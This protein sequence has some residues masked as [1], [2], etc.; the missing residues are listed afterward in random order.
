[1][2]PTEEDLT[3]PS[4]QMRMGDRVLVEAEGIEPFEATVYHCRGWGLV[5]GVLDWDMV[6]DDRSEF[7]YSIHK[8]APVHIMNKEIPHEN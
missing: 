3:W 7:V 4:R 6:R 5:H 2:S 1:M 8:D